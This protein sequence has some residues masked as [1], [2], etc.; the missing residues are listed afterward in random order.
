VSKI[1]SDPDFRAPV[2]RLL[3]PRSIAVVGASPEPGSLGNAVLGNLER[4]GFTGTLHLVS[5]SRPEINGRRCVATIDDLPEGLDVVVLVVPAAAVVDAVAACARRKAAAAVVFA[6][7][8][9]EAGPD[10][11]A[12]Q[13]KL[14]AIARAAGLLVLG[15]NCLGLVNYRDGVPL[16]FEA[17]PPPVPVGA[18]AVAV[19]AQSGAMAGTIRYALTAKGLPVSYVVSTGNEAVLSAEAVLAHLLEDEATQVIA[20]FVEQIR[21]PPR[22]LELARDA[23][24]RGKPLVL[25][26]PGRSARARAAAQSHTGALAGDHAVM[27]TLLAR[28]S[29]VVVDTL[30][31]LFDVTALLARYPAP[32]PGGT[33]VM[34][35][36][37]AFCGLALD[38]A[39][40]AGLA[41]PALAPATHERLRAVLPPL[42]VPG[43]PLDVTTGGM[44]NPNLFG[45]AAAALLAD[46]AVGSLVVSVIGGS[47]RQQTDK[48]RSLAPVLGASRKPVTLVYMGDDSPIA[49]DC[50]E[51][52]RTSGVPF[53]R[54]PDR[55][56]RAMAHVTAY[57]RALTA[58]RS[59]P[60]TIQAPPL[61]GA[62]PIAEHRS[63]A[64]LAV[65]GV[66]VPPSGLARTVDDAQAIA[67]QIGF[68]VVLKAQS[69][70]LLHKTEAGGIIAAIT[71]ATALGDSWQRLHANVR[72]ARPELVLDGVLVEAMAPRGVEMIVGARR[73]PEWGPVLLVGLGGVIAEA[74]ADVRLLPIDAEESEIAAEIGR[75]KGA[76]LLQGWRGAPA[77]DV[78]AV[79]RTAATLGALM[80]AVTCITEVE[81]NPL[82]AYAS[83]VL[84]LDALIVVRD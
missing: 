4:F 13:E 5:R 81:I 27:R 19:I 16:T 34:S 43:N 17:L 62:G 23:R 77:S 64:Y 15:P 80:R 83:G 28:E 74:L 59:R 38:V 7:G 24:R 9:G 58:C 63:K 22:F 48:A 51:L 71:D 42:A 20:V 78:A 67:A 33:A 47:P 56:L 50:R 31:E 1:Y 69:A 55:A 57:G 44:T 65:L 8:F 68:P 60:L 30:D 40:A 53:F 26:H 72:A 12:Q 66:P 14:A 49:E 82:V 6:S 75:L 32:P 54:S 73:D 21:Q 70:T 84:A 10:G 46:D 61:P 39:E 29:V 37:G 11:K 79:A 25:L 3:R 35:N 36:S 45:D 76:R 2:A 18:P 52:I 41:L